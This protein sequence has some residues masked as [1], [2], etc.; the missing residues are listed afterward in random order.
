M[1]EV[2]GECDFCKYI[3]RNLNWAP[4]VRCVNDKLRP[5]W[6]PSESGGVALRLEMELAAAREQVQRAREA[7]DKLT[8]SYGDYEGPMGRGVMGA[9]ND[10]RAALDKEAKPDASEDHQPH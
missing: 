8:Q 4:C 7:L 1:S 10:I 5:S 6:E 3:D 9:V 2:H